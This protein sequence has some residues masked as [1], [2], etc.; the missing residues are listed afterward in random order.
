M[1]S[2]GKNTLIANAVAAALASSAAYAVAP[3]VTPDAVFYAAGGS[4]QA[5]AFYVASCKLFG[6][7]MDVYS[8]T[9]GGATLSSDYYVM[10]GND[11]SNKLGLGAGKN[12]MYIY[13]FNGGSFANGIA[14]QKTAA[15]TTLPYP[16]VG[17]ST[18]AATILG[19]AALVTGATQ[20][21]ACTTGLPTYSYTATA[22]GT[23]APDFG[24]A[25]V[26]V[27]TF[28]HFNN[29]T[30]NAGGAAQN[31]DGG[32]APA[33]GLGDS[34]YDNLFGIAVTADVYT[35]AA[36]PK[37]S[38]TRAEVAG[39]LAG[40]ISDWSQLYDDNG[41]QMA[42]GGITFLDRGE[43]SGTKASG[44]QYFLGYP[45]LGSSAVLP[46]SATTGYCGTT[47]TVCDPGFVDQPQDIAEASTN[48]VIADLLLAN[49]KGIRA[50]GVLG[51]ENPPAKN[52]V[53]GVN[54]YDFTK[55]NGVAVDTGAAGDNINGAVA[56]SY[57][58]VVKGVYDF[59]FQNSFN[60]RTTLAGQNLANANAY[61]AQMQLAAFV[62]ANCNCGFPT[63]L[64]GTLQD[65]DKAGTLAKGVTTDTRNELATAPLQPFFLAVA[66]GIPV[67]SDPL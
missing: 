32:P 25:D 65:A 62:G 43:G 37:T 34:I 48:A 26:N 31:T 29:P 22:A 18:T 24:L 27:A 40:S 54:Q 47:L 52:L 14:P 33:V 42:A 12:I 63:G 23:I 15:P 38:F 55:I 13:K 21:T 67:S 4:A 50:V 46:F 51:L 57:I 66:G 60:T 53:G 5:N 10:Y 20:G 16:P 44:N 1:D 64:P 8:D 58:N 61:K 41:A 7:N 56:T 35:S 49:S 36:H 11:A 6:T 9:T 3:S 19:T 2:L 39:I 17:T 45:G 30:G 59:Y 28:Q